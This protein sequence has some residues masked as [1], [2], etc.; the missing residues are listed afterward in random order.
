MPQT[1]FERRHANTGQAVGFFALG[2][3]GMALDPTP[4]H[5]APGLGGVQAFAWFAQATGDY[6]KAL[7]PDCL[8]PVPF[9]LNDV[10]HDPHGRVEGHFTDRTLSVH[11]YTN[12]TKPWLRK[13][14]PMANSY[15]A[16]MCEKIDIDPATALED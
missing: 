10:F 2:K 5:L 7:T 15:V 4:V 12:G 13:N 1:R 14:P 6:D 8:S 11:P 3:A 16:R 9:Q